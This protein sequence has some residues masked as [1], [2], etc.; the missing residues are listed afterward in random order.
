MS[1]DPL[2]ASIV[3]AAGEWS[4]GMRFALEPAG[5]PVDSETRSRFPR[6]TPETIVRAS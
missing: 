2:T 3:A 5:T 1:F 6:N 4:G